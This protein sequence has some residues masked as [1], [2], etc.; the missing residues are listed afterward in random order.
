MH[1]ICRREQREI[2]AIVDDDERACLMGVLNNGLR[3]CE[4]LGA[5]QRLRAQLQEPGAARKIRARQVARCPA[6]ADASVDVDDAVE[7]RER[8]AD[9][10]SDCAFGFG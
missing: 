7:P 2:G 5:F 8:Q 1:T 3:E 9:S 6:D 4:E 10:A